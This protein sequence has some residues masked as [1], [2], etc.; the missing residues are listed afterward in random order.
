MDLS[1]N[2][3]AVF[4]KDRK[5]RYVLWR[6][7]DRTKPS[8]MFIGLNPSNANE[9][10]DDPTIRRVVRFARDWGYGSVYMKNLFAYITPDPDELLK[11]DDPVGYNNRWL[12]DTEV[13]KC[14]LVIFA[15]GSFNVA[16]RDKEVIK[17]FPEGM[18]LKINKDGSPAHPLYLKGNLK[19]IKYKE[20]KK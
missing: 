18:A 9:T 12:K 14:D 8:V 17:M 13:S 4:S 11:C 7:W 2:S 19:P 5:Y 15:W 10:N 16:G 6:I 20:E 3:G 1:N